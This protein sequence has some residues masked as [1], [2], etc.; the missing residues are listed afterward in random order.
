MQKRKIK[1][2]SRIRIKPKKARK[3]FGTAISRGPNEER[4][5]DDNVESNKPE[6]LANIEAGVS[7]SGIALQ[8][9]TKQLDGTLDF[10]EGTTSLWCQR[11]LKAYGIPDEK[12]YN[13]D[14]KNHSHEQY[15]EF[16]KTPIPKEVLDRAYLI[17]TSWYKRLANAEEIIRALTYSPVGFSFKIFKGIYKAPKGLVPIPRF[18][19]KSNG[20]HSVMIANYDNEK[21]LLGFVN[22]WGAEWGDRGFGYLTYK[23]VD[24]YFVEAWMDGVKISEQE[25]RGKIRRIGSFDYEF[26]SYRFA[27]LNDKVL[28]IID[29]YNNQRILGWTHFVSDKSGKTFVVEDLFILPEY[30]KNGIGSHLRD[31]IEEV[32]KN[33]DIKK[34]IY[35]IHIQDVLVDENSLAIEGLL[36]EE[37]G[38]K[39]STYKKAFIGCVYS[40]SKRLV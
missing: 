25:Q 33:S 26:K 19:E 16:L 39:I 20:N 31:L 36:S 4:E 27:N 30:R 14:V 34:I 12:D 35:Y 21:N 38:Y 13:F 28:H 24:K 9:I 5:K 3:I 29:V 22:S 8:A 17:R 10:E 15:M 32:A 1:N 37:K 18:W 11:A 7:L 40:I 2:K 6:E 23:Y